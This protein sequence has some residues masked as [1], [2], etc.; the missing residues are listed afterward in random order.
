MNH[1]PFP[2][3]SRLAAY[4]RDSGGERQELSIPQQEDAIRT[5]CNENGYILTF[6]FKDE[7]RP[8]S[9]IVGRLGFQEMMHHFRGGCVEA[10]LVIWNYQRFARDIDDAQFHRADLRRRGYTLYSINDEIPEGPMGRLFEAAID[11]KNE[12]F[13]IDLSIDVKRGLRALV[14]RYGAVPGTPPRGFTRQPLD[15]GDR[16]DGKPHRVHRW[17]PDPDLAP[18]VR[19][20]FEMR[21]AGK[22]LHEINQVVR[23]YKSL[24]CYPTFFSNP[25]YKGELHFGDLAILDYCEPIV[26]PALWEAVQAILKRHKAHQNLHSNDVDHPRRRASS[27]LLSGLAFCARCSSPLSGLS[28]RQKDGTYHHRYACTRAKR[29]RDCDATPIPQR[30]LDRLILDTLKEYVLIPE[31]LQAIQAQVA[32]S[33]AQDL[34]GLELRR[35]EETRSLAGLRRQLSRI[36]DAIAESGHSRSLLDKLAGLEA[37]EAGSLA[38]LVQ[39]DREAGARPL[40]EH[41][42]HQDLTDIST[43]LLE[44]LSSPDIVVVRSAL[45]GLVERILVE[46]DDD[47]V[48]GQITY[49]FPPEVSNKSP[50]ADDDIISMSLSQPPLGA[51]V[52]RHRFQ[53][54]FSAPLTRPYTYRVRRRRTSG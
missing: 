13:L 6:V 53:F 4:L 39:I 18:R 45:R 35:K 32:A 20:A 9:S 12:Q 5:W 54:P 36:T 31:V 44:R 40:A 48:R 17:Q 26:E 43:A 25:L 30:F 28:V 11:W 8:G 15:I 1:A 46:R 24:N 38:K 21:A 3:G 16:R 22:S 7:A 27:Y 23:L 51:P 29:V 2:P 33:E 37:E 52:R 19:Q 47:Q 14:E 41:L 42:D 34:A 49:Y 10:G 50:P